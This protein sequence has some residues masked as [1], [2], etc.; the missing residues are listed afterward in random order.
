MPCAATK[1]P[2]RSIN[3]PKSM[4][5]APRNSTRPPTN[6]SGSGDLHGFSGIALTDTAVSAC[7]QAPF[8]TVQGVFKRRA[9]DLPARMR[10]QWLTAVRHSPRQSETPESSTKKRGRRNESLCISPPQTA[11]L[12]YGIGPHQR[13]GEAMTLR[14]RS[15]QLRIYF[16]ALAASYRMLAGGCLLLL[17]KPV[18][19]AGRETA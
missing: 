8:V 6:P 15:E 18:E 7:G 17:S 3:G 9:C 19:V 2:A 10:I 16:S 4:Q 13:S 12:Q 11:N 5:Y 14:T 1:N